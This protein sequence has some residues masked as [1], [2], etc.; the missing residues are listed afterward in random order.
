[1]TTRNLNPY[2]FFDQL[3]AAHKPEFTFKGKTKAQFRAWQKAALPRVLATLGSEPRRV[4]PRPELLAEWHEDGL[5]KQRWVLDV[6]PGLAATLLLFRPDDLAPDERR[7]AIMA[8]H[9]H[10]PLGKDGPMGNSYAEAGRANIAFHNYAYGLQ[11]AKAGF[12]TYAIDWLGFG[13]R[14]AKAKPHFS[15]HINVGG[16][17]GRDPCN[18][19]YLNATM[20]GTTVLAMNLHDARAAT[21]FVC[22]QKFVDPARLGVMGLS[23]G[24]TMTTWVALTDPR[25]KA[26]D[27][28][29]YEGPFHEIAYRTYNVCG[30]QLTP[31]LFALVDVADL[32]GLLAP[33][34]LLVELGIH[35]SCF[36]ADHT[37][38]EYRRLEKI[39][40][41]AGVAERIE[42]D[43]FPGEHSWGG[44]KS[45][46]FF[47]KHLKA[48]WA[49]K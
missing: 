18:V 30:S 10:G 39:Y 9:G 31:G 40:A 36:F 41:A 15:D 11:M 3:G 8:C 47:R 29:C 19:Y 28:I 48:P 25:M 13:E 7:P 5:V 35:D 34:P 27:V 24:G 49:E 44:H 38:P 1:M 43:L 16:D 21:D 17:F 14:N 2:T 4:D 22:R 32:Q 46:P 26:I 20:L 12:V 42:L 6:Q 45:V 33:R 37:V 23:L